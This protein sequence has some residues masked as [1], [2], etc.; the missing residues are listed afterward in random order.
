[1]NEQEPAHESETA[2]EGHSADTGKSARPAW[3]AAVIALCLVA[4]ATAFIVDQHKMANQLSARNQELTTSLTQTRGQVQALGSE[5]AAMKT[6]ESAKAKKALA[7]RRRVSI[8]H[9][10]RRI[11]HRIVKKKDDPRWNQVET[12]LAEHQKA[13][14]QTQQQVQAAKTELQNNL[15]STRNELS[16][17]IAKTHS[18]LVALEQ[19]GERS[20]YEFDLYK[21]KRFMR[22]GPIAVSLRKTNAKHQYCNLHLLV[23]DKE[24][25]KKHVNLYEPVVFYTDE[26]GQPLEIV[27]N[28]ISRHHMHGYVSSPKYQ[29]RQTSASNSLPEPASSAATGG[30]GILPHRPAAMR[31]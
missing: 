14:D 17:S 21:T 23:D 7:E 3:I 15:S 16:G 19:K 9:R 31:Q 2:Y 27:I 1:M 25:T 5:L 20:Y 18:E 11:R 13:I 22:V 26:S 8:E 24:L 28:S 30:I 12:E 6:Q 10:R 4:V 29:A